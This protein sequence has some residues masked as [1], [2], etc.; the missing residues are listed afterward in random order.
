MEKGGVGGGGHES[1]L[2]MDERVKGEQGGCSSEWLCDI[3]LN[4]RSL[5]C[6]VVMKVCV[7][8]RWISLS[9]NT[10]HAPAHTVDLRDSAVAEG[11]PLTDECVKPPVNSFV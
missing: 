5:S 10:V 1:E 11:L 2:E 3:F 6:S 9:L 4:S 8:L 7:W